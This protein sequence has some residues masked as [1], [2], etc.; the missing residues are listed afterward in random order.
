MGQIA[1][2]N[3]PVSGGA[4]KLQIKKLT[5]T[6]IILFGNIGKNNFIIFSLPYKKFLKKEVAQISHALIFAT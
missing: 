6:K 4:A 2:N 5:L 1:Y 3:F